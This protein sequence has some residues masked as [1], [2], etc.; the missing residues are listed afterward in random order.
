MIGGRMKY[1]TS[2]GQK[3]LMEELAYLTNEKRVEIARELKIAVDY[4]DLRENSEYDAVCEEFQ[5]VESRI[6]EIEHILSDCSIYSMKNDGTVEIGSKVSLLID[7]EIEVYEIVG[8]NES[9]IFSNKISYE[10][11]I[12]KSI[13]GKRVNDTIDVD[14]V[15][16]YNVKIV[17]IN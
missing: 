11:I 3:K 10:S 7:D 15:N 16:L 8:I 9:D 1:L 5:I 13:L 12:G 17:E 14:E 6:Y 4:G 2:N